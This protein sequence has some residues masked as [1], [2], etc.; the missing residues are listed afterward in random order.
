MHCIDNFIQRYKK[1]R[2]VRKW[3][4]LILDIIGLLVLD[5]WQPPYHKWFSLPLK[6][7]MTVTMETSSSSKSNAVHGSIPFTAVF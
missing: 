4:D 1:R 6:D 2:D 7:H 5:K 3:E